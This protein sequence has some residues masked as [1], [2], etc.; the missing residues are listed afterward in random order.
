MIRFPQVHRFLI[1]YAENI[2]GADFAGKIFVSQFCVNISLGVNA[3]I[4]GQQTIFVTRMHYQEETTLCRK[5]TAVYP[6]R[7]LTLIFGHGQENTYTIRR[8]LH[9]CEKNTA[10]YPGRYFMLICSGNHSLVDNNR[11]DSVKRSACLHV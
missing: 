4:S 10:V 3:T 7:Y 5:N 2:F 9:H 1:L 11:V 6:G 8:K